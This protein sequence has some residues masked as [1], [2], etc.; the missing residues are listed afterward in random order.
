MA[1]QTPTRLP[2]KCSLG[3]GRAG[4]MAVWRSNSSDE[5]WMSLYATVVQKNEVWWKNSKY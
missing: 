1:S 5:T 2:R 3:S 4:F